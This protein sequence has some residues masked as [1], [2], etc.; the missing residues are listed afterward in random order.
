[1]SEA[2]ATSSGVKKA[3]ATRILAFGAPLVMGVLGREVASRGLDASGLSQLLSSHKKALWE[4]PHTPPGLAGAFGQRDPSEVRRAPATTTE[5]QRVNAAERPSRFGREKEHAAGPARRPRWPF[6]LP[7]LAA[8]GLAVWGITAAMHTRAPRMGVTAPQPT[9]PSEPSMPQ[10]APTASAPG[11]TAAPTADVTQ[12][13]GKRLE[14]SARGP[15]ADLAHTLAD[16]SVPLPR[17]F[18]FSTLK[19]DPGS[20]TLATDASETMDPVATILKS[21]PSARVRIGGLS[22]SRARAV[23]DMLVAKGVSTGQIDAAGQTQTGVSTSESERQS[24]PAEIEL[25]ER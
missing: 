6:I 11:Q 1:V 23:K 4:D 19:F 25:V 16:P 24:G 14:V 2:L 10:T 21:H 17:T 15:A 9:A 20:T 8:A 3:S 18:Q 13:G 5:E 7:A 22:E 12:P